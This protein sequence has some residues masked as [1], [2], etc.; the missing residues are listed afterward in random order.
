MP[1]EMVQAFKPEQ[2]APLVV[3]LASDKVPQPPTGGLFEVGSGWHART[4]WQRSGGYGFPVDVKLT[5]EAVLKAWKDIVNFDD[6]RADHPE[7]SQ[8]GIRSI[9]KN[10]ENKSGGN[11]Q[12]KPS[13]ANQEILQNIEKAKKVQSEGSE[14]VYD[15]KDIILY[16]LGLGAKRTELPLVYENSDNF[17]VL[18]T[19]GVIPPFGAA[20]PYNM[21][22]VMPNFSPMKLL[23]GEQYLELRKFPI[24]LSAKLISYPKLID[25]I[26]KGNAAILVSRTTTKN[27]ATGED[28]FYNEST[29][30][31][32]GSGGFGG[33]TKGSDRG[34]ATIAY[35]PPKRQPDAVVEEATTEEQAA[36]YRLNGDRNPLHIDPEFSKMG[37]FETP[38]L[39]GLCFMG[40]SGKHVYQTFGSFKNIKVRFAG[41][42]IP[43]QRL[44]T[45]M[46]KEGG[47]VVFQTKVVETVM[48]FLGGAGV[49]YWPMVRGAML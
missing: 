18:P 24:P 27:A 22:E 14:Y 10:M 7:D 34:P 49:L 35:Q 15:E 47:R 11:S 1:E 45:E 33:P 9:T 3:A 26:D 6:G 25:V 41:T 28:V 16:N 32:R 19:F 38:I 5:P 13:N 31:V 29:V 17:Q 43:G 39:H 20:I 4:R 30:L 23:H 12:K 46:W 40:I 44:R 42:V 2:V 8:D 37:G 36:L 21:S 48:F